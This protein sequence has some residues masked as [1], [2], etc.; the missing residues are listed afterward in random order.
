MSNLPEIIIDMYDISTNKVELI[1]IK[2]TLRDLAIAED[3]I[4]FSQFLKDVRPLPPLISKDDLESQFSHFLNL[5]SIIS[6]LLCLTQ[7]LPLPPL[8]SKVGLI[9]HPSYSHNLDLTSI[10]T[11]VLCILQYSAFS[12]LFPNTANLSHNLHLTI[13]IYNRFLFFIISILL[14][15]LK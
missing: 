12:V 5:T 14:K 2:K 13:L 10:I 4:S 1:E 3:V 8:I 11:A 7:Y 15:Y 6:L 9:K